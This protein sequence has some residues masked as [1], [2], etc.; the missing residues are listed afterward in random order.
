[1][2]R[3]I[4]DTATREKRVRVHGI[5]AELTAYDGLIKLFC[6]IFSIAARWCS[7]RL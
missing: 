4:S 7:I 1:M 5:I 2:C 3:S 6:S